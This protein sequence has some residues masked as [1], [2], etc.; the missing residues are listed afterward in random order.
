[1][2]NLLEGGDG[3]DMLRGAAGNDTL[4]GGAG[5]DIL[6]GESGSDTLYEETGDDRFIFTANE[7]ATDQISALAPGGIDTL[8][9]SEFP[10]A[11]TVNLSQSTQQTIAGQSSLTISAGGNVIENVLVQRHISILG[12]KAA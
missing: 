7:T 8:D 9:F 2:A 5:N 6:S 12:L 10:A 1:L 11:I 4:K 3:N